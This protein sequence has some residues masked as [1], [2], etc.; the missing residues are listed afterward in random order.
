MLQEIN[1]SAS[2]YLPKILLNNEENKFE[3]AGKSCPENVH[4]VFENVL[5]WIDK[6]SEKPNNK[7]IFEFKLDYYNTATSKILFI[8]MQKLEDIYNEGNDV[9]VKW[10]YPEDDDTIQESGE[11]YD[12]II[13][14]PFELIEY[15]A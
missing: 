1:V 14:I 2:G 4:K 12:D 6:Y 10:Y 15:D 13:D 5:E 11:E 3:I 9:L 8:I 7:T